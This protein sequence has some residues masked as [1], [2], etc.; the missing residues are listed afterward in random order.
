MTGAAE[1][2][3]RALVAVGCVAAVA[4]AAVGSRGGEPVKGT[5]HPSSYCQAL[6]ESG[7]RRGAGQG[8][9]VRMEG[10]ATPEL[11]RAARSGAIGGVVVF[12]PPGTDPAD[13]AAEITRLRD[14]TERAGVPPPI[15]SIDQEGGIVKRLPELA[16]DLAPPD[17]AAAGD[18]ATAAREGAATGAD[19]RQVGIDVD[20]APVL[21]VPASPTQ[22]MAPRAFGTTPAQVSDL[23]VAFAEGL[24]TEGVAA[25]AKHFPGLGR[26]PLNTDLSPTAVEATAAEL[27]R[28]LQPF[29]DA[30]DAG[31]RLMMLSSAAYPELGAPGPAVLE[32]AVVDGLLRNELG[33]AGATIS[34][35]LLAPALEAGSPAAVALQAKAAGIDLLLFARSA[36]GDI[37]GGLASAATEGR[38]DRAAI[39][40][41]CE[42]I[43]AL[44][45]DL[46]AG[47][48]LG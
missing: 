42:R 21:D 39:V 36:V 3:R 29:A 14:A 17:I 16:P 34:D 2:R 23:G 13:L 15:V 20:L 25:T 41:S 9:V 31:V 11:L 1:R 47:R 4:G 19:L 35:D 27:R 45:N 7:L 6:S 28:D 18:R 12:P 8:V 10:T 38:I 33:Y 44:K 43:L 40:A 24:Q 37:A 46:A 30:A 5:A 26:A 32:P 48:P 22:F